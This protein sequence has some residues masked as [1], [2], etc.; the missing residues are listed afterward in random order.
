MQTGTLQDVARIMRTVDSSDLDGYARRFLEISQGGNTPALA[1]IA[2]HDA[3]LVVLRE[4]NRRNGDNEHATIDDLLTEL[5][6]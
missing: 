5:E 6:A 3:Y 1:R 4:M 2:A